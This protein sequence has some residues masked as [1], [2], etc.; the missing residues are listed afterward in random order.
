MKSVKIFILLYA[1]NIFNKRHVK[2]STKLVCIRL[3]TAFALSSDFFTIFEIDGEVLSSCRYDE[4]GCGCDYIF[5]G[6][7]FF[8]K[9]YMV[10]MLEKK[11]IKHVGPRLTC[12]K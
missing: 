6:F 10:W 1:H 9:L 5:L 2:S 8:F 12:S 3:G 11:K 7:W 4:G